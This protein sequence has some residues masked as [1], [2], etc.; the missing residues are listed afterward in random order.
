MLLA[1]CQ[2]PRQG[3]TDVVPITSMPPGALVTVDGAPAGTT[4]TQLNLSRL[5]PHSIKL[6]RQGYQVWH[7]Q[8]S[9][10]P[11]ERAANLVRFGL[12]VDAGYYQNLSPNPLQARLV[13]NL[14]PASRGLDP[15]AELGRRTLEADALLQR[16]EISAPEHRYIIDRLLEFFQSSPTSPSTGHP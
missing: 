15:F 14:V 11:N 1:S 16:G 3:M 7:A 9:P 12:L 5:R 2:S 13:P 4:P 10:T 6:E 8:L